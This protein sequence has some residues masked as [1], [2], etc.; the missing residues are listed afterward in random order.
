VKLKAGSPAGCM[1]E[2]ATLVTPAFM[3]D[4]E[5]FGVDSDLA[6]ARALHYNYS[7]CEKA[8]RK[9]SA[10]LAGLPCQVPGVPHATASV[11]LPN[12]RVTGADGACQLL[13]PAKFDWDTFDAKGTDRKPT[14]AEVCPQVALPTT[15]SAGVALAPI[16]AEGGPLREIMVCC[17]LSKLVIQDKDGKRLVQLSSD[18]EEPPCGGGNAMLKTSAVYELDGKLLR[19][20]SDN[21]VAVH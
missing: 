15:H 21:S 6:V 1:R 2:L 11:A 13:T 4:P 3:R 19:L 12:G 7:L 16:A 5:S 10:Q 20:V 14:A 9:D 17:Q 8:A 18:E